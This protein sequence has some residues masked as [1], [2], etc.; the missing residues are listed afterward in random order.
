[1]EKKRLLQGENKQKKYFFFNILTVSV[2]NLQLKVE[3]SE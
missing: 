3:I 2:K 1:M